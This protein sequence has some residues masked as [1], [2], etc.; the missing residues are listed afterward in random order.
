MTELLNEL[1]KGMMYRLGARMPLCVSG[2]EQK[3]CSTGF[4]ALS[5]CSGVCRPMYVC[6]CESTYIGVYLSVCPSVCPSVHL[7]FCLFFIS[8]ARAVCLFSFLSRHAEITCL[9]SKNE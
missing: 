1:F 8:L 5:F 7:P 6:M 4:L 2:E 3:G 9:P